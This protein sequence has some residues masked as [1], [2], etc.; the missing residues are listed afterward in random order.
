MRGGG[1]RLVLE[2]EFVKKAGRGFDDFS[3]CIRIL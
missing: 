1:G 3:T 2:A